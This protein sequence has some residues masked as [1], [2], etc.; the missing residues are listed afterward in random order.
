[1]T[2]DAEEQLFDFCVRQREHF[3]LPDW[4]RFRAVSRDLLAS[5]ALFLSG[6][7]WY[8]HHDRLLKVAEELQPGSGSRWRELLERTDFETG[9][10]SQMLR[11]RL[12]HEQ[13]HA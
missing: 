8:G 5:V 1:M 3:S 4:L 6:V 2:R 12:R 13:A 9:R 10:F 7:D 11:V